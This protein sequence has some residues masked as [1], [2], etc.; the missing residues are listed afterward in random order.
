MSRKQSRERKRRALFDALVLEFNRLRQEPED[1]QVFLKRL[2]A[3]NT[4]VWPI[5]EAAAAKW[6]LTDCEQAMICRV[7]APH[8]ASKTPGSVTRRRAVGEQVG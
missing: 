4:E 5:A 6:P 1:F 3:S 8:L 7:V 2:S